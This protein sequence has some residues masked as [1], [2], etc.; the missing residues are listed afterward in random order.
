MSEIIAE[1]N[2]SIA[3]TTYNGERFLSEQLASLAT[4]TLLPIELLVCDDGSRD[5]TLEI[6]NNFKESAPFPVR[7][8]INPVRLGY[9][10]NFLRC[11]SLCNGNL[12]AFCDQ[13]DVW[14]PQKLEFAAR[15]LSDKKVMLVVHSAEVVDARLQWLGYRQ[16]NITRKH[17][18]TQLGS[19]PWW[20]PPGFS[21]IF[22]AELI[23]SIS[24]KRRPRDYH[25]PENL[26]AHD[27][28]IY[29]LANALG[30]IAYIP[31][32]LALY[33]QHG[34]NT[35]GASHGVSQVVT[36][37]LSAGGKRYADLAEVAREHADVLTWL[38]TQCKP[39]YSNNLKEAELHYIR[40]AEVLEKRSGLYE[41]TAGA[42]KRVRSLLMAL[43]Q[44]NYRSKSRG[45][46]GAKAFAK[47]TVVAIAPRLFGHVT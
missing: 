26:L 10:E 39:E 36:L 16:P 35:C 46:L 31:N 38:I 27:K 40:L 30:H 11:A 20:V 32:V 47:D 19:L 17:Q 43:M 6:L 9:R 18:R 41:P 42:T 1:T 45:G 5:H 22:R 29:F 2:I 23:H 7:I 33:R 28:W 37:T 34:D 15:E 13:D 4:Q 12:I 21:M 25:G 3:M 24:W 14:A 44:S 8:Q